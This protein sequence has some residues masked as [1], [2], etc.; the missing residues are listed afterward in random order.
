VHHRGE[1][2][3]RRELIVMIVTELKHRL[4]WR[5]VRQL[6]RRVRRGARVPVTALSVISLTFSLSLAGQHHEVA[7]DEDPAS[8]AAAEIQ[9]ARDRANAA[10]AAVEDA[11][12]EL[13]GLEEEAVEL[14]RDRDKLAAQV[15][16]L[17]SEVEEVASNRFMSGGSGGE[18]MILQ[19][20]AASTDRIVSSQLAAV[21]TDSS[22]HALDDYAT[23]SNE[24]DDAQGALDDKIDEVARQRE[25]FEAAQGAAE[26]E[27]V[28]L[29]EVE[30]QRLEDERVR[31]ILEQQRAAELAAERAAAEA[32]A[33]R[34]AVQ[35]PEQDP[36]T[37]QAPAQQPQAP[38]QAPSQGGIVEPAPPPIERPQGPSPGE[39]PAPQE[40]A[41]TRPPLVATPDEP[42]PT[43]RPATSPPQTEPPQT[44]P[45]VSG[46]ACPVQGTRAYTDTWG[47]SRSGG[48]SHQGVDLIS[49]HGTP[50][51]AVVSG[52]VTFKQ[53]RLGGNSVWLYGNNGT[54][55]FYAHLS[56]FAGS[57]R[58]VS[59][60]EVIGYVGATGNA[61][62]TN[63]LHFEV[64]PGGG[65]AV[66][67]YSYVRAAGC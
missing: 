51:V 54:S 10:A 34:A 15:D 7:A 24:L 18:L 65:A 4:P 52:S 40:P 62:G 26:E 43:P 28:H 25:R 39:S 29:Q 48:R 36:A 32:A 17:R 22:T 53:T 5:P 47:A 64:H 31:R 16:A 49:P 38:S 63:H 42:E 14:E 27:V 37:P 30:R 1:H 21:A 19:S 41:P 6:V 11:E 67:P 44:S 33:Q 20:P 2:Q 9:A 55:Y 45:P 50:I 3:G 23:A 8:R 60:G 59:Q 66:N 58:S 12:R 61:N 13:K 57:S 46:M 56:G 35:Q